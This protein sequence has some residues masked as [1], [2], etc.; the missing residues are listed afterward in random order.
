MKQ[1]KNL[2]RA[3]P[4]H[5]ALCI[6]APTWAQAQS[7]TNAPEGTAAGSGAAT[8]DD[9]ERR[10]AAP[11]RL[12]LGREEIERY[13]DFNVLDVLRRLPT[14]LLPAS[15]TGTSGP[16]FRGRANGFTTLL[17]DD[18][19][20]P[21]GFALDTLSTDQVE[22]IEILR[23]PISSDGSRGVALAV[24]I[25][26]RESLDTRVNDVR[27]LGEFSRAGFSPRV[28]WSGNHRSG[29]WTT[30]A[31]VSA[32]QRKV[33]SEETSVLARTR[34]ATGEVVA[35]K[36]EVV[37]G[38]GS[39]TGSTVTLRSIWR[40]PGGHR[41]EVRPTLS[42]SKTGVDSVGATVVEEEATERLGGRSERRN[43]TDTWRLESVY[44]QPLGPAR[45]QWRASYGQTRARSRSQGFASVT[46][47]A[48][49]PATTS[50]AASNKDRA[51]QISLKTSLPAAA[52]HD[53]DWGVELQRAQRSAGGSTTVD[54]REFFSRYDDDVRGTV[55]RTTVYIQDEWAFAPSWAAQLGLR[56]DSVK[57]AAERERGNVDYS[58][59]DFFSP[60]VQVRWRS[61]TTAERLMPT[62]V[63][64]SLTRSLDIPT[65]QQLVANPTINP[66]FRPGTR[67]TELNL[68]FGAN[69]RL[70][71][72][73]RWNLDFAYERFLNDGGVFAASLFYRQIEDLIR[74]TVDFESVPWAP[75]LQRYISRPRN[76]G[77][78]RAFGGELDMR[79]RMTELIEDGPDTTLRARVRLFRSK[80]SEVDSPDNVLTER[81][82]ASYIVGFAHR[83]SGAPWS[84]GANLSYTPI[85]RVQLQRNRAI[86]EGKSLILD[87]YGLWN[88]G[89]TTQLRLSL[90]NALA[91]DR[92]RT[93]DNTTAPVTGAPE[94][95]IRTAEQRTDVVLGLR[96]EA[97]L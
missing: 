71:P 38:N 22:R 95:Q 55:D 42:T 43:T 72:E 3:L 37:R 68:D 49:V 2:L 94:R 17:I 70:R 10:R 96:I 59:T 15:N 20:V 1:R 90:G 74:N 32:F 61:A 83:M 58:S 19:T 76:I 40:G 21:D 80:V 46:D 18:S 66:Y 52:Q 93:T 84:L 86:V 34:V 97:R 6:A 29:A 24:N 30:S 75:Q 9:D 45:L 78:A 64:M 88:V 92:V 14:V 69:S 36:D 7:A 56:A 81:P 51:A 11:T 82:K 87:A 54:D 79:V 39:Q 62:Q 89:A 47:P 27:A 4:L 28:S 65:L 8:A 57:I 26:L 35:E 5:A 91:R 31:T 77:S 23:N 48:A 41:F 63:R 50:E 73:R 13:G 16:R 44:L 60:I 85:Y 53:V 12:V 25:V 67:N 33:S